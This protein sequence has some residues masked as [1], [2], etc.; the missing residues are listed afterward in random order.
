MINL[1]LI[2]FSHVIVGQCPRA[3]HC[4][5][6]WRHVLSKYFP[7]T[8]RKKKTLLTLAIFFCLVKTLETILIPV[9]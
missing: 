9:E 4:K 8:W 1:S 6:N 2:R 7:L 3:N 5:V